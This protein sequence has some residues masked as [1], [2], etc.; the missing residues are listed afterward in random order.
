MP[1]RSCARICRAAEEKQIQFA[2]TYE[3]LGRD[4]FTVLASMALATEKIQLATGLVNAYIRTPTLMAMSALSIDEISN[5]RMNLGLGVSYEQALK[6][7]HSISG[8]RPF[9]YLKECIEVI[10][11]ISEEE[12]FSYNGE[13]FQLNDFELG[14]K[15]VRPR[16]P[17]FVGAHNPKMLEFAGEV[18]DG[19]LLNV[20]TK[21]E[22]EF[23]LG[24]IR[25]GAER[26]GRRR[27]DIQ[28]ASF[29]NCCASE[30]AE[31]RMDELRKRMRWFLVMPH[32]LNRLRRTKFRSEAEKAEEMLRS[33]QESKVTEVATDEMIEAMCIADP[34]EKI[35]EHVEEFRAMGIS[36]PVLFPTPI[37]G[38][39]ERGYEEILKIL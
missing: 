23:F 26:A 10:R 35:L 3:I 2:W 39:A 17:I 22:I 28:V 7:R 33:G 21:D 24:H 16:V 30:S 19:V 32:I 20:V 29:F 13:I 8:D 25:A 12:R 1:A 37:M 4:A 15:P 11:G 36:Q 34:P 5:G 9:Q 31:V 38:D 14:Y 27:E 18:A 6:R